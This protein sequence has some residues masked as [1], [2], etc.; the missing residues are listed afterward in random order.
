MGYYKFERVYKLVEQVVNAAVLYRV[1]VC[2]DM[3]I[4]P[5]NPIES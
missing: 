4:N 3:F 1:A 5:M 2:S